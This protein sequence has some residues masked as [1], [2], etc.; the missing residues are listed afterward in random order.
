MLQRVHAHEVMQMMIDSGIVYTE[1]SLERAIVKKFGA[2]ARFFT[3]SMESMTARELID[4]LEVLGKFVPKGEG[5]STDKTKL[6][7]H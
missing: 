6:C 4:C 5:F 1:E 7:L 2:D 3:C